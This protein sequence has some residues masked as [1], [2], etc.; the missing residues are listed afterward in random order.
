MMQFYDACKTSFERTFRF[1][2]QLARY[3]LTSESVPGRN[4]SARCVRCLKGLVSI[5]FSTAVLPPSPDE[6]RQTRSR[7]NLWVI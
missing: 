2:K 1:F 5:T 7:I 4:F 6:P 3:F